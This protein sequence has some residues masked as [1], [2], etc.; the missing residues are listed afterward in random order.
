MNSVTAI[1]FEQELAKIAEYAQ[2]EAT[3][4]MQQL[5]GAKRDQVVERK[6]KEMREERK[7]ADDRGKKG[8]TS[9]FD[10]DAAGWKDQEHNV[11]PG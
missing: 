11:N 7:A 10:T 9:H 4:N 2:R 5:F 1:A 3:S 8:T 6:T